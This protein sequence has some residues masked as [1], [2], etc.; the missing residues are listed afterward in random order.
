MFGLCFLKMFTIHI[1]VGIFLYFFAKMDIIHIFN[2]VV[3]HGHFP[4]GF[5]YF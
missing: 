2:N 1:Y 5:P 4:M 3:C